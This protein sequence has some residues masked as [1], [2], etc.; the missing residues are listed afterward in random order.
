MESFSNPVDWEYQFKPGIFF[1]S[2]LENSLTNLGV[3]QVV[4]LKKIE[5]NVTNKFKSQLENKA[6]KDKKTN[7]DSQLNVTSFTSLT[8][9][10]LSQYKVRGNILKFNPDTNPLKKKSHKERSTSS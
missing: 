1:S 4:R 7:K 9:A 10:P 5:S 8:K 6:K 3:F 2:M